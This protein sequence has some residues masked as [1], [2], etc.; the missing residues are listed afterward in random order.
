MYQKSAEQFDPDITEQT[1]G[2]DAVYFIEETGNDP[3]QSEDNK[4][5]G[6]LIT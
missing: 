1:G 5:R 3:Y 4:E 2:I 6:E